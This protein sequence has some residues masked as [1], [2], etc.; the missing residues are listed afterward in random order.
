MDTRSRWVI[1]RLYV[2]GEDSVSISP[3]YTPQ[4]TRS[5]IRYDD[6]AYFDLLT[7][8]LGPINNIHGRPPYETD[9][10]A[11]IASVLQAVRGLGYRYEP[12]AVVAGAAYECELRPTA[13]IDN[14]DKPSVWVAQ[15]TVTHPNLVRVVQ[16]YANKLVFKPRFNFDAEIVYYSPHEQSGTGN[17]SICFAYHYADPSFLLDLLR[18]IQIY[19]PLPA[20]HT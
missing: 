13:E 4:T 3:P 10:D 18:D 9:V 6:P 11:V 5:I 17:D 14:R 8:A 15:Y 7:Q 20:A 1:A 12:A 2:F 16:I 19:T